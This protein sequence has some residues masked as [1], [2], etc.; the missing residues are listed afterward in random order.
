MTSDY[1]KPLLAL[2]L[3][4]LLGGCITQSIL[5]EPGDSK[6]GEAN[7]QTMMAQVIDPDPVYTEPMV[8]SG[9]HA[10]DAADRYHNGKVVEPAKVSTTE[11]ASSGP[12]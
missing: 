6:F 3:V 5:E 1:R 12:N 8:T 2:S 11:G 7:R 9:D 10:A 4:P